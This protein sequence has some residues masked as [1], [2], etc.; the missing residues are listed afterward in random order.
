MITLLPFF[1][2]SFLVRC[3]PGA[4]FEGT[5]ATEWDVSPHYK[6]SD[7]GSGGKSRFAGFPRSGGLPKTPK[8][9]EKPRKSSIFDPPPKTRNLAKKTRRK[10]VTGN[11]SPIL[12]LWV[13]P[14]EV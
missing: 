6:P 4:C 14:K 2:V 8:N 13:P 10:Y 11:G 1:D 5:R 9:P 12:P 3:D 7:T